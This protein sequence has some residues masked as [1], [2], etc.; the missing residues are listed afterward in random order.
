VTECA[1]DKRSSRHGA[2][3][4]PESG[5]SRQARSFGPGGGVRLIGHRGA[6]GVAPENTLPAILHG[7]EVGAD[8]IELDIRRTRDGAIVLIHDP[9]L[10]RTTDGQGAVADHSLAELMELDAGFQFTPD[11]GRTF[12]FRGRGVRIPTLDEAFEATGDLP[13]ILEVKSADAGRSLAEWL[14]G[15][16]EADRIALGGFERRF[17]EPAAGLVRWRA[18]TR[19]ELRRFVLLGKVGLGQRFAPRA[20]ALMVPEKHKGIRVVSRGLIRRCHGLGIGL[21]VWTVNRPDDMRRLLE[22]GV[23]GLISD[24]P[25]I[26][27]RVL[28]E[29]GSNP[30][31]RSPTR[32]GH[33]FDTRMMRSRTRPGR[34]HEPQE[35]AGPKRPPERTIRHD[36]HDPPRRHG[37]VLRV[38]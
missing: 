24:Y 3:E 5:A 1:S 8:A 22:W 23:D 35:A 13:V 12:P 38:G 2:P 32:R 10:E 21:F 7:V 9:T 26:L 15:R 18:A 34:R 6:A 28:E 16:A 19:E 17:V 29:S 30:T 31:R 20:D 11:G 27:R 37:R 14:A 33:G 4:A 25:A 36:A